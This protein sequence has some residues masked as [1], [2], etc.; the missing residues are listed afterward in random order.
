MKGE[1]RIKE[2][3]KS[4]NEK[5]RMCK[6]ILYIHYKSCNLKITVS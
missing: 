6:C 3:E 2:Y 5:L 1:E 4:R